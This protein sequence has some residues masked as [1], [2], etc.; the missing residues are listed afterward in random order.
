MNKIKNKNRKNNNNNN[1]LNPVHK[2]LINSHKFNFNNFLHIHPKIIQH[3]VIFKYKILNLFKNKLINYLL[4][5]LYL[6]IRNSSNHKIHK[7]MK[8]K[9]NKIISFHKPKNKYNHNKYSNNN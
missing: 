7:K 8:H 2:F 5:L 9:N 3:L 4:N 6:I 1:S